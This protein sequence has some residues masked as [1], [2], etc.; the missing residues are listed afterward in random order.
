MRTKYK[1]WAK[2]YIEEHTEVMLSL[3][4]LKEYN[5]PFFLEIG[6]GKGKF[7]LDMAHQ[8]PNLKFVGVERNVTCAGFA[9]KKLVEGE[10]TNAK[11]MFENADAVLMTLKDNSIEGLFLNFSDPWPKKRHE[12]RR[13]THPKYLAQYY[14]VLKK[15]G[16]VYIKTDN[17]DLYA[18]TQLS[19]ES[20]EFKLISNEED[21]VDFVEFDAMTEYEK[22]FRE[23]GQKI[24]RIVLEKL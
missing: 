2:P 14:R 13:L 20:S 7:L 18:Y 21:Y 19:I 17:D 12:K 1:P 5:T 22:N 11:L 15:G 4:Q 9:A 16:K 8:F 6:S 3:E 10:V 23:L 24:H